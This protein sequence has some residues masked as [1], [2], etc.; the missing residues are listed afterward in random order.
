MPTILAIETSANA[1]SVCVL[2][3]AQAHSE[4]VRDEAKLSAWLI[5]AIDR[6]LARVGVKQRELTA[7]AFGSG[8]GSFTGVRSACATA[9]ALAYA[10]RLPLIAVGSLEA[11]AAASIIDD[12]RNDAS[13][14]PTDAPFNGVYGKIQCIIDARMNQLY[15]SEFIG[16][17]IEELTPNE[18]VRVL[19]L[20]D[21]PT[22]PGVRRIGSGALLIAPLAERDEL[23]ERT[24]RAEARWAEGVARIAAARLSRGQAIDPLRAE[25]FYVRNNVAKTEAE[26]AQSASRERAAL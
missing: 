23:R 11:L 7:I 9:Q 21:A 25:P 6:L 12:S 10:H 22:S 26:R 15:F 1:A 18:P 13:A 14:K 2:R 8:P 24:A 4:L 19:E 5:P 3:D 16:Q 20:D 17:S